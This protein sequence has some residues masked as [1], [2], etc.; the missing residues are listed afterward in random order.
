MGAAAL[1]F[2]AASSWAQAPQGFTISTIVG[3]AGGGFGGDGG[4]AAAAQINNPCS[5][6]VDGAGNIYIGDQLNYRVRKISGGNIT[7]IVGTGTAGDTGAG[8]SGGAA[9]AAQIR[10]PCGLAV[11]GSGN[12]FLSDTG[13]HEIKKVAS[14]G[15]TITTIAGNGTGGFA[16]N[17]H[18]G[19]QAQFDNPTGLVLDGAGNL[20]IADSSNHVVRLI[21]PGT[22][23]TVQAFA[24]NNTAGYLGDGGPAGAAELDN[25][26]G[27]AIDAAGN[28]YVADAN[29]GV[30]RKVTPGGGSISTVAGTGSNG[31][32][33]DGGKAT[34]AM[35]NHPHGVA[36][37]AAGNIY[38]A[39]TLNSRIRMVTPDGSIRTIAGVGGIGY[40]GDSGDATRAALNF[41]TALAVDAAGNVYVA[42]TQN[43]A[44][45]VL[46][47]TAI[48]TGPPT[49]TGVNGASDFGAFPAVAPGS[50]IEVHGANLA[51]N[52]R[53]WAASDFNGSQAPTSLDQISVTIGGQHAFVYYISPAQIN[54]QVPSN[55]TPGLQSLTVT[56]PAGTSQPVN[57]TVNATQPGLYAPAV[58]NV[59]GNQ[60]TAQYN[61]ANRTFIMPP[62]AVS[63]ITSQPAHAGDVIVLYGVGFGTVTPNSPAGQTVQQQNALT[64]S[65]Q[66]SIGGAPAGA[67]YAGLA[68]QAIGLYQFNLVVPNISPGNAVPVTFSLG[69]VSGTQKLYIAVQ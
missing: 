14:G 55:V 68:P 37:D 8:T 47:P 50:W 48:L 57:V 19:S 58:L 13:N 61:D 46:K 5:L 39:D 56:T 23:G 64:T 42:D 40:S 4:P 20:Y 12:L 31:Y 49:V 10:T 21:T 52:A 59:G 9:T 18:P 17:N 7:T 28:I 53:Q 27:L 22:T 60:Y 25:P 43:S 36:V 30:I 45:R 41:P 66:F 67:L 29:S 1:V 26:T 33:G 51:G 24:G 63:G 69:G 44:I 65:I 16:G 2:A 62:G 6:V 32:S 38:I 35:L 11:D 34:Q 15:G 3:T 54:V